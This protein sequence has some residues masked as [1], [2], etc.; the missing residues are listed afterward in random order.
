MPRRI[1]VII[2]L[3]AYSISV[4]SAQNLFR[5]RYMPHWLH[6]A[7]FAGYYM[8]KEK[9]IYEKYGLDVEIIPGGPGRPAIPALTG[10]STDIT[11]TFLSGAIKARSKGNEI[12][13]IA[14]L[15]QRSA[16]IYIAKSKSGIKTPGDFNNKKIGIWRSDFQEL[17]RAFLKKYDIEAEIIPIT[18]TLTLFLRDGLDIMCV[19]WYNEY[20][21]VLNY[22]IN[23]DELDVF[24]F[25]DYELDFP[26][27]AIICKESYYEAHREE[28]DKFVQ[29]TLEGWNDAFEHKEETLDLVLEYMIKA[30]IPASRAH[31][32]WMLHR[33]E[34]IFKAKDKKISGTLREED[35]YKTANI[36]KEAGSIDEIPSFD[37]FN[38]TPPE[39]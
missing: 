32:S 33:M 24:H 23:P 8:A 38:K 12:V 27:D 1:L 34:D 11:S 22:G 21:Q 39:E 37:M 7:Q 36:L 10:N 31:Q 30:N 2:F 19:M 13:E 20:H 28:C 6:Q 5:I 18:K 16:L 26:E 15:S 25:L 4:I 9:G 35:F 3:T 14:Q 17:P 29:A